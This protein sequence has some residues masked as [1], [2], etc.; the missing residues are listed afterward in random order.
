MSTEVFQRRSFSIPILEYLFR[1]DE[2]VYFGKIQD[3]LKISKRT[4][5]LTLSDLEKEG[6]IRKTTKGRFSIISITE[7]GQKALL[8]FAEKNEDVENIIDQIVTKTIIQLEK[9]GLI[10]SSMSQENKE[11]FI[12]KLKSSI[13]RN[14]KT[15]ED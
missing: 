6:L 10:K 5:Y 9:E 14:F 15:K 12:K 4:L 13:F 8:S 11:D 2:E 3:E 7:K 1:E